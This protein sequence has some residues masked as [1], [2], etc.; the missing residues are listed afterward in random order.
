MTKLDYTTP[1]K[2]ERFFDRDLFLFLYQYAT[3]PGAFVTWYLLATNL[4]VPRQYPAVIYEIDL[5]AI[6]VA[7]SGLVAGVYAAVVGRRNV[8]TVVWALLG[9]GASAV[10]ILVLGW[11]IAI[12][13]PGH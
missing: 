3:I 10:A 9:V 8:G 13:G 2:P 1:T 7:F 5:P 4:P 6:L 11:S 12:A